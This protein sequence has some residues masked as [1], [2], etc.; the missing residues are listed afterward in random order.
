MTDAHLADATSPHLRNLLRPRGGVC[1][2]ISD[3]HQDGEA[4]L[5]DGWRD[6]PH[7]LGFLVPDGPAQQQHV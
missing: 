6:I 1:D 5:L 7:R 2:G 3:A 4:E